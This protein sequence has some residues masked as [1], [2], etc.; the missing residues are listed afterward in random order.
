MIDDLE[1]GQAEALAL[2]FAARFLPAS[3]F[4]RWRAAIVLPLDDVAALRGIARDVFFFR[5]STL[6][7]E[8]APRAAGIDVSSLTLLMVST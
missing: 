4:A 1:D 8:R 6:R 2:A 5:F 7:A 3:F